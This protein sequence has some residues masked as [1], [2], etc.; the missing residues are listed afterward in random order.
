MG[1]LNADSRTPS[2]GQRTADSPDRGLVPGERG[3]QSTD[4]HTAGSGVPFAFLAAPEQPDEIGRLG[5]FRILEELGTGGMG[6]VFKAEDTE[7]LRAVALKVIRPERAAAPASRQ[8]FLQEARGNAAVAHDHIV[9]IYRVGEERG[10]PYL[11][12]Q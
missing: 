10:V 8:R 4:A 11:A 2:N 12:M 6:V 1:R 7:L 9:T 5:P 3:G